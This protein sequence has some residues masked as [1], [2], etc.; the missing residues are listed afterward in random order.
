MACQGQ[1]VAP[2]ESR[3]NAPFGTGGLRA[4]CNLGQVEGARWLSAVYMPR[5]IFA[6]AHVEIPN[7]G[8]RP[9]LKSENR[10]NYD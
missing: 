8:T 4:N 10:T 9:T 5:S 1:R 7:T 6:H 3:P 2:K